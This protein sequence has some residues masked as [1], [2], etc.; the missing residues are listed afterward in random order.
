MF[1][2]NFMVF[3][4]ILLIFCSQDVKGR[5]GRGRGRTKSRV[6]HNF[7]LIVENNN[8]KKNK[9]I[10]RYKLVCQSQ[11]NIEIPNLINIITTMM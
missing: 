8:L 10:F 11:E 2:T 6:Q 5:R 3:V 9:I 7:N 1:R 4:I